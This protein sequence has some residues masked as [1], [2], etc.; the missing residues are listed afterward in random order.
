M[1]L[2]QTSGNDTLT[3][4]VVDAM[5]AANPVL[6]DAEF[7][8]LNGNAEYLRKEATASGGAFR[9]LNSAPA[10][11]Q[12]DPEFVLAA[13]KIFS[14]KVE[15][16]IAHER[17]GGDIASE[18]ARQLLSLAR[19][20]GK[21]LVAKLFNGAVSAT[22]FDGLKALMPAGQVITPA[23]D[24]FEVVTGNDNTAKKSQQRFIEYLQNLV[25]IVSGGATHLYMNYAI[26]SRLTTIAA[27]LIQWEKNEF[28]MSVPF[29]KGIPIR[30]PGYTS[31]NALILGMDEECGNS[32][33]TGSVYAVRWGEKQDFTIGTNKGVNVSDLGLV[34]VH[35]THLV[36]LDAVPALAGS[37]AI[38]QLKGIIL[39]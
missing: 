7:Y 36:E 22:D 1:K 3:A 16:D 15:V 12:V 30:D 13:L 11:N 31:A 4:T 24:G 26:L 14:E 34:G 33:N 21:N 32:A 10:A 2:I 27:E 29:F 8:P 37:K 9:A 19:N 35:Y 20:F 28:G 25:G 6:A 5:V 17:R 18:R 38:A 39:P 23:T